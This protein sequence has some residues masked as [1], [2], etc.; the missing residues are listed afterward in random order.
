MPGHK[1]P[2]YE[3]LK[4]E[5]GKLYIQVKEQK[6]QSIPKKEVKEVAEE[7][8]VKKPKKS[9]LRRVKK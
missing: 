5:K 8:V 9:I 6:S 3:L 4:D 1:D 7:V 2:E